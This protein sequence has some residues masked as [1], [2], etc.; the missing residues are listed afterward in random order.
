MS[1]QKVDTF[2]ISRDVACLKFWLPCDETTDY[3]K[4]ILF[5]EEAM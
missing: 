1:T 4:S 2:Y 3:L 5:C